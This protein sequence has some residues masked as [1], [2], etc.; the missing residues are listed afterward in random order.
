[1]AQEALDLFMKFLE[2]NPEDMAAAK[3]LRGREIVGYARAKGF[4]FTWD[5]LQA[6]Q[7]LIHMIEGT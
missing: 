5:E 7:A 4:S 2:E 3:E 6:R 1:M